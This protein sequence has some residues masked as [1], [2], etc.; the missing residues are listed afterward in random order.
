MGAVH[1]SKTA[2]VLKMCEMDFLWCTSNFSNPNFLLLLF[3]NSQ[4]R[5]DFR[6]RATGTAQTG[7]SES[8]AFLNLVRVVSAPP[9][10]TAMQIYIFWNCWKL[11]WF[12]QARQNRFYW[13]SNMPVVDK[14]WS[15]DVICKCVLRNWTLPWIGVQILYEECLSDCCLPLS[16]KKHYQKITKLMNMLLLFY[17]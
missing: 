3:Q 14:I 11:V 15:L 2:I 8:F 7:K 12:I 16:Q 6:K 4:L 10:C 17:I 9:C 5:S 13:P 1:L